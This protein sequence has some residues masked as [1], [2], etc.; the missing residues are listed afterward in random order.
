MSNAGTS[1]I[2]IR[3]RPTASPD[4][5]DPATTIPNPSSVSSLSDF[6]AMMAGA[7]APAR[8]TPA[9]AEL[10]RPPRDLSCLA[11]I[12]GASAHVHVHARH[13]IWALPGH[14]C[15]LY[16][17]RCHIP[18]GRRQSINRTAA[19]LPC[20]TRN[21]QG[22]TSREYPGVYVCA[23][24]VRNTPEGRAALALALS[25][26]DS[27]CKNCGAPNLVGTQ[28]GKL[29]KSCY[30]KKRVQ[31]TAAGRQPCATLGC[32]GVTGPTYPGP[33]CASCVKKR[34]D[35]AELVAEALDRSTA[36]CR[37][38]KKKILKNTK[39]GR[40]CNE[41]DNIAHAKGR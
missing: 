37:T 33:Y 11:P 12:H 38:C 23:H 14:C 20:R 25:E 5:H 27:V 28:S 4:V 31:K 35:A 21:C 2:K 29:C 30:A 1:A 8:N 34:V 40:Y 7:P 19:Q 24:C 10:S 36:L 39:R 15:N 3:R 9:A 32:G 16:R 26:S 13:Q 18:P 6:H 41:C 22:V 17:A